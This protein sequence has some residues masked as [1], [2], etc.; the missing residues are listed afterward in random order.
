MTITTLVLATQNL[1]KVAEFKAGLGDLGIEI[2]SLVD[3]PHCPEI[4]EDGDTFAANALK[5][6]RVAC[7]FTSYPSLADDSGLEVKALGG[8]PGVHSHRFAG[9]EEDDEANNALLLKKLKGLPPEQRQAQF[10]TV[11]ALVFD[12][13]NEITVEG[14][15]N[16]III[17][18]GRGSGGFGYDPLFYL[19]KFDR[20]MAE[21]TIQEKNSVSH[22]G[23]AIRK[24][25]ERLK[26]MIKEKS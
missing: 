11:V 18:K 17:E 3:F 9:P 20:T 4:E 5:K 19:P 2:K 22:R 6:A 13:D 24:L 16:G 15:C 25:R 8:A 10:R 23:Q 12:T 21:L 26:E 14:I 1:G 7:A